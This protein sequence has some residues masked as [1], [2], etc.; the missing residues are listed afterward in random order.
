MCL[1]KKEREFIQD[2]L[3]VMDGE[4]RLAEFVDKWKSQGKD[5]KIYMRVLRHRIAR[6][7]EMM[8]KD[9]LL[10]KEFLDLNHHP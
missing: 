4:M 3:K 5:W 9:A 1:S 6:K 2:W 10:M 8:L 7:Y